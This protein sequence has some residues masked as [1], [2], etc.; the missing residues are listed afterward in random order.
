[1]YDRQNIMNRAWAIMGNRP[2]HRVFWRQSLW[3]AWGEAKEAVR[4]ASM[5]EADHIR[6][7]ISMLENKD[8]WTEADYRQH[9]ELVLALR[10]AQDHEAK[11]DDYAEKRDLIAS[12]KG[13]FVSVTFTKQDGTQRTM[14]V[15]PATLRRHIKGDAASKAAR[16]AIETRAHRHPHLL[17]VWDTEAQAP[18]SVNLATVSRIAADGHIH[19]FT[20]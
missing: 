10:T 18:R 17:A 9:D 16:K 7:A 12:A 3:Q 2:F 5:T 15:Q 6:E 8:T 13:R 14:R 4:R 11:A 1:M 20:Q 19:H